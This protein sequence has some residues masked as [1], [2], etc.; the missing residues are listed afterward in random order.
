MRFTSNSLES[1]S[2]PLSYSFL[3]LN[4]LKQQVKMFKFSQSLIYCFHGMQMM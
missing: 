4:F 2:S 1:F 3:S